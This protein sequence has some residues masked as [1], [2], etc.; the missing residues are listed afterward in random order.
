MKFAF[1]ILFLLASCYCC[2]VQSYTIP[3]RP[4]SIINVSPSQH[5]GRTAPL[6]AQSLNPSVMRSVGKAIL[7]VP[8]IKQL[9]ANT[10]SAIK[11]LLSNMY[12]GEFAMI[13]LFGVTSERILRFLHKIQK[14]KWKM[15]VNTRWLDESDNNWD[16]S[17][18]GV[19]AESCGSLSKLLVGIYLFK[20][21]CLG[22]T[23]FG[24]VV[25][26]NLPRLVARV[27][28]ILW[29]SRFFIKF[30]Q[31]FLSHLFPDLGLNRRQNYL[32]NKI[33]AIGV[34]TVSALAIAEMV[35]KY[36]QISLYGT[37]AFGGVAGLVVG[38]SL[39][40]V[41]AN[42]IGGMML[43]MNEPFTP[44]DQITFKS[45]GTQID[46]TVERVGWGQTRLVGK[47]T[48]PTYVP[49]SQFLQSTVT[50][51]DR[52]THYRLQKTFP[53]RYRD[54]SVINDV[55][56]RVKERLLRMPKLDTEMPFRVTFADVTSYS[57]DVEV[58]AYFATNSYTEFLQ[59]QQMAYVQIIEGIQDC[60][61][62]L[63]LP[64][65]RMKVGGDEDE[66]VGSPSDATGSRTSAMSQLP[67]TTSTSAAAAAG[68]PSSTSMYNAG[69]GTGAAGAGNQQVNTPPQKRRYGIASG[70][71]A[72]KGNPFQK[73]VAGVK[74]VPGALRQ[75]ASA[76]WEKY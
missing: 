34:W 14:P 70:Y 37:L 17:V 40:D 46:G 65:T 18:L 75:S 45:E 47:D 15:N 23:K 62:R 20:L 56:E 35:S 69:A 28:L 48:T 1:Q 66:M 12:P 10:P 51:I 39:K 26:A 71:A 57:L 22:L 44:G 29:A 24:F 33:S 4:T 7:N 2:A 50:N 3:T 61:A 38:M 27:S 64:T 32:V 31:K 42:Y 58:E 30:E 67:P 73:V 60:G 59:L 76:F 63:A 6:H 9:A 21:A 52:N 41:V 55:T 11:G 19:V 54:F 72:T 16:D 43:L 49:N 36:F 53:T 8:P 13:G 74:G 68:I 5:F 25:S